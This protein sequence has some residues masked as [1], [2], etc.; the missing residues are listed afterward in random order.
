ML[1]FPIHSTNIESFRHIEYEGT[2]DTFIQPC[3]SNSLS[4][5]LGEI[6]EYIA[7]KEK[8]WDI[9]K[10]YTNTYEYIHTCIPYKKKA[11][12]KIKPLS[13][14]YFKMMEL[15]MTFQLIPLL[16]TTP[17]QT[18]HLAEGPGGFIEAVSH[19]RKNP[20]DKYVGMT[21]LD[22]TGN[23]SNIPAWKKSEYFLRTTP[24]V[25]IEPGIDG[26]GN[27]LSIDNYDFCRKKYGSTMHLITADGGFDFSVDFNNQELAISKLLFA[28]TCFAISMQK[29]H[30]HFILK[31][32]DCF[33]A[34]TID[35]IYLLSSLYQSVHVSKPQTSRTGN[36]EKYVVCKHFLF[37]NDEAI[38]PFLRDAFY[39]SIHMDM[40]STPRRWLKLAIPIYFVYRL[41]EYN[42]IFGQQQIENIHY[43]LS[44]IGKHHKP[45]KIEHLIKLNIQKCVQWCTRFNIAYNIVSSNN[46]F[47][48]KE[49][50]M[51][52]PVVPVATFSHPPLLE[53]EH[54]GSGHFRT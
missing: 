2:T 22:H 6:K 54:L 51:P 48:S 53:A 17:I 25:K 39:R 20:E 36:S 32:F 37:E 43:T 27:I 38:Y 15:S 28:Q 13:R 4:R 40:E 10:K 5:Y 31:I 24:Q 23:N 8:E 14:S 47:L 29:K 52:P 7:C 35:L 42:S 30:G 12:S 45:E 44:L 3:I 41:E 1:Y 49:N 26:T 16:H 33:H 46:I 50:A 19:L 34:C 9:Y 21:I 11:V 18:F